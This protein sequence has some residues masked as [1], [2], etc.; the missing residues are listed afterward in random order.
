MPRLDIRGRSADV[1]TP[2]GRVRAL[3]DA[4]ASRLRNG[5]RD[6]TPLRDIRGRGVDFRTP[7]GRVHALRGV[8]ASRLRNGH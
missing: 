3:R 8:F 1:R 6:V 5:H 4:F 7:R 2:H